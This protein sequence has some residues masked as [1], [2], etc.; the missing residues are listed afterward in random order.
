MYFF[1]DACFL[2]PNVGGMH[3]YQIRTGNH[4]L[5]SG[6]GVYFA[7]TTGLSHRYMLSLRIL[8]E[9]Q[10]AHILRFRLRPPNINYIAQA[11]VAA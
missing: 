8:A 10:E 1:V 4:G 11:W 7:P 9:E 2:A 3:D 5:L 6:A